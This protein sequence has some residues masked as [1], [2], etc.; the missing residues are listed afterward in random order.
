MQSSLRKAEEKFKMDQIDIH[1][2]RLDYIWIYIGYILAQTGLYIGN[3]CKRKWLRKWKEIGRKFRKIRKNYI[4]VFLDHFNEFEFFNEC[5]LIISTNHI[6]I[7]YPSY[8]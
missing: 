5:E 2:Y 8:I 1:V 3:N 4:R 6:K 7:I